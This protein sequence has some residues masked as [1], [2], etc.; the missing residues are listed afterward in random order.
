MIQK[1]GM[2]TLRAAKIFGKVK[3]DEETKE[4]FPVADICDMI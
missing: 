2:F 1:V 3:Y 4:P